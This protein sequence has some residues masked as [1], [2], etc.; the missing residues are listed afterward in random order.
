MH[1]SFPI[2]IFNIRGT[3]FKFYIQIYNSSQIKQTQGKIMKLVFIAVLFVMMYNSSI[4]PNNDIL[5]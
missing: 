1:Q 4:S 2:K 5:I 3:L